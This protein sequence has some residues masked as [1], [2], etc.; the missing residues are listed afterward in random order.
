MSCPAAGSPF[1]FENPQPPSLDTSD[2][3]LRTT[4]NTNELGAKSWPTAATSTGSSASGAVIGCG[5]C[6][7]TGSTGTSPAGACAVTSGMHAGYVGLGGWQRSSPGPPS[8]L[9]TADVESRNPNRSG[10]P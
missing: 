5:G 7:S 2:A 8:G 3:P 9:T 6:A 4:P 1:S 10:Q